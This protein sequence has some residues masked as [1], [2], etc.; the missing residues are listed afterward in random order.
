[1]V[2][3]NNRKLRHKRGGVSVGAGCLPRMDLLNK[4]LS[5]TG[6]RLTRGIRFPE[7]FAR[8]F[9]KAFQRPQLMVDLEE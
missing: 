2:S 3:T 6:N 8:D 9:E 1:M 5:S 4:L 7:S